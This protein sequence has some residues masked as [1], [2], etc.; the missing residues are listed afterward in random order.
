MADGTCPIVTPEGVC[1]KSL[2]NGGRGWCPA[3]YKR[4]QATGDVQAD[5]PIGP[6]GGDPLPR[7]WAKVN[8]NGP[9]PA[10]RPDLGPCWLWM[11]SHTKPSAAY[12]DLLEYGTFGY[13]RQ[14]VQA[15]RFIY[16]MTNGP[17]EEGWEVDH[18]CRVTL[19]VR[20]SHLEAVPQLENL[21]RS[22]AFSAVNARKTHCIHGHEFTPENTRIRSDGRSRDCIACDGERKERTRRERAN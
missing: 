2:K 9:V 6:Y 3:H 10:C 4:W 22:D 14:S 5:K 15:H 20:L 12:P 7:F 8:K 17:V 18:L 13:R 16:E 1:G 21:M 11:A 19:C